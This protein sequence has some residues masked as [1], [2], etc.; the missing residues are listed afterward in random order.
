MRHFK[1]LLLACGIAALFALS[2]SAADWDWTG[3][4][5]FDAEDPPNLISGTTTNP[6]TGNWNVAD[7]WFDGSGS[8]VPSGANTTVLNFRSGTAAY[9]ATHNLGAFTL[10]R[11]NLSAGDGGEN[12]TL[13]RANATNDVLNFAGTNPG[14]FANTT[15]TGVLSVNI[16]LNAPGATLTLSN[17]NNND[18]FRLNPGAGNINVGVLRIENGRAVTQATQNNIGE[19]RVVNGGILGT[20]DTF[21]TTAVVYFEDASSGI[22]TGGAGNNNR[23]MTVGGWQSVVEGA[24]MIGHNGTAQNHPSTVNIAANQTYTFSGTIGNLGGAA[25]RTHILKNGAGTQ[26]ITGNIVSAGQSNPQI[27]VNNGLLHFSNPTST[28][29]GSGNTLLVNGGTLQ[30][31]NTVNGGSGNV[32]VNSNGTLAG[33]GNIQRS[34]DIFG[35]LSPGNSTG[36]LTFGDGVTNRTMTLN[37]GFSYLWEYHTDNSS[38]RIVI[39]GFLDLNDSNI[40]NNTTVINV[41]GLN[42]ASF[43]PFAGNRVLFSTTGGVLGASNGQI[44]DWTVNIDGG[45][46]Q[47]WYAVVDGNNVILAIPEPSTLLLLGITGIAGLIGFRRRR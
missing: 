26:I 42:G 25:G 44:L 34:A 9:T 29:A 16:R 11:I 8:T 5:V 30:I 17:N 31:D 18:L 32:I 38:D 35:T 6:N 27:Q 46:A 36:T 22:F 39:N 41:V 4:E 13:G 2:A 33:S 28:I 3:P 47:T 1:N 7:H 10:N 20:S 23:G 14:I 40:E 37:D 21:T 12:V 45:S 15:G 19:I 43:D 24:G